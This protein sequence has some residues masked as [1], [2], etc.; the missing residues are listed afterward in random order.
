MI[1]EAPG[2]GE[3]VRRSAFRT[4]SAWFPLVLS[5][6]AIALLAGYFFTGPHAPVLVNDH[7]LVREDEGTAA[8]LWQ[9]LMVGQVVAIMFF[10][11]RW[12]PR[13]GKRASLMLALQVLGIVA[14]A[15]PLY[16]AEHGYL[17]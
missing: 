2:G 17:G 15:L 14:A 7:G 8:H 16:L 13:D 3:A 4:L 5:A 11:A 9:V 12:L 6:A 1:N 10:A